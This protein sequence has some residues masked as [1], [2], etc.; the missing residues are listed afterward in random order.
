M[1]AMHFYKRSRKTPDLISEVRCFFWWIKLFVNL[2]INTFTTI[3]ETPIAYMIENQ[4]A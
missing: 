2:S 1:V 4:Y 3:I